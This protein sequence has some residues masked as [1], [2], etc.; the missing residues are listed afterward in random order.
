[1]ME[2][3]ACIA[4]CLD[5]A[6]RG[7]GCTKKGPEFLWESPGHNSGNNLLSHRIE[8]ALPS[9]AACLTNVFGMGTCI[10]TRLSS[11]VFMSGWVGVSWVV[12]VPTVCHSCDLSLGDE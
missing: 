5:G 10:S 6:V 7:F 12:Q 4:V 8:A 9:A 1:M 11:P 3:R 2:V